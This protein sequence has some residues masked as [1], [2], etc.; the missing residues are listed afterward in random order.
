MESG[1]IRYLKQNVPLLLDRSGAPDSA[2]FL[3]AEYLAD[4]WNVTWNPGIKTVPNQ[5]R[6]GTTQDISATLVFTF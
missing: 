2:W 4:L 3:A 5:Y 1:A 6:F